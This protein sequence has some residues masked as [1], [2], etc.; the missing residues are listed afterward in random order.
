M[1]LATSSCNFPTS[2]FACA[3]LIMCFSPQ[4]GAIFGHKNLKK[5][6]QSVFQHLDFQMSVSPQQRQFFDTKTPKSALEL[7]FFNIC[8][9]KFVFRHS[10]VQFWEIR[11]LKRCSENRSF[12]HLHFQ[13]CVSACNFYLSGKQQLSRPPL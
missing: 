9:S 4:L 2:D 12:L 8:T 13:M 7:Q 3:D 11:T 1:L 5:C 6:S 10:D